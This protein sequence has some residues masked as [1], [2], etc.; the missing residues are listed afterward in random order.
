MKEEEEDIPNKKASEYG[1][2]LCPFRAAA[3]VFSAPN[4]AQFSGFV[5]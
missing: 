4:I 5:K 1:S 2:F 3:L